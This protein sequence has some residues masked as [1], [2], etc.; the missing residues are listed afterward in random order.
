MVYDKIITYYKIL[1]ES[2][3]KMLCRKVIL[4]EEAGGE[5]SWMTMR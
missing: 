4:A 5:E 2:T 3:N 1:I